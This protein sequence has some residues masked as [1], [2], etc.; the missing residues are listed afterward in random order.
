MVLQVAL[1]GAQKN[2]GPRPFADRFRRVRKTHEVIT[3]A[4]AGCWPPSRTGCV[5]ATVLDHRDG[6]RDTGATDQH[7]RRIRRTEPDRSILNPIH[8]VP[9]LKTQGRNDVA[10]LL[11]PPRWH[12]AA[13]RGRRPPHFPFFYG[14]CSPVWLTSVNHEDS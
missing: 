10:V 3:P 13:A 11:H 2:Q 6:L 12:F 5:G 8:R 4:I 7:T 1:W 14:F 9:C